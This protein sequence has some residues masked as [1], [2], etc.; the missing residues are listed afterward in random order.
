MKK[1]YVYALMSAVALAG[2]VSL[3]ACS[4]SDDVVDVNPTFDGEAVKTQFTISLPFN[5]KTQTRQ[6]STVVQQAENIA[7]FRGMSNIVLIPFQN[8]TART[9]RL[10]GNVTLGADKMAIPTG[11]SNSE[12][13]I[14]NGKLLANSNAVLYNDVTIPVGTA[15]FLFYGKA[16]ETDN[17]EFAEG[18]LTANGLDGEAS[19][20]SFTPTPILTA[21][22]IADDDSPGKLLASYVSSI[23][24]ASSDNNTPDDTSDDIEY[25]WAK[26]ASSANSAQ[27]WYNAGLGELY[28]AFT[29]MKAGA[30]SYI[31]AAVQDLYASIDQNTDL[32]SLAIKKAILNSTYASD[33]GSGTLTF[34]AAI[35]G[36]PEDNEMPEG[37]A[38]LSWTDA[39]P[40]VASAVAGSNFGHE[41]GTAETT[42]NVVNMSSIVYPASLYY[43]VDSDLKTS[44]TSRIADYD[45]TSPWNE[46]GANNN[47]ID[48]Y[49]NGTTVT[50]TT[51]SVAITKPIQYAVGRLDVKVNALGTDAH[52]D[53][54][55]EP[56]VFPEGTTDENKKFPLTAVLIGGQKAVDYKFEPTGSTEYTI[57]DNTINTVTLADNTVPVDYVSATSPAGPNYTLA[58]ETAA[59]TSIYV[60]LEFVNN[61]NDF[62]GYDG[63]VKHGC[64][65]Y[66][67]AKLDPTN[68]VTDKVSGSANTGN[69]V[70]KQDFKT[71]ANFTIGAGDADANGD[72]E[73]DELKG[74]ANAYTTIPDLRTPQLEL[75]FSVDLTWRS[76]IQFDVEF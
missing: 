13:A 62:Q 31:Q 54:K 55:G 68:D 43:Y 65:F 2:A 63:V 24:A 3:S 40:K 25:I 39:T 44:N 9:A 64:K 70:F 36:Y 7:S 5:G 46:D 45:G 8:A 1:N 52:Y 60:A 42:M 27:P 10:G 74:F 51:R 75:G 41:G 33:N 49:T 6:T 18:R 16:P 59:N 11:A 30:S 71:I 61:A 56:V 15:G 73:A 76:G 57:Y 22:P 34:T 19:G 58:L 69:K 66:M 35:N 23:A 21:D 17:N 38:A 50:S 29:S 20:I 28:T 72:G 32:V 26:C 14:P 67:I 48:K 37:S 47:I 4:T 12:N 53:R